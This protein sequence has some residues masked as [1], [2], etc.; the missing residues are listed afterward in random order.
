MF[1]IILL[2]FNVLR[3]YKRLGSVNFCCSNK[4]MLKKDHVAK[5]G[6]F[7]INFITVVTTSLFGYMLES[8][9]TGV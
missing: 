6:L 3:L 5:L 7:I 2:L 1:K 4:S 8:L 9:L